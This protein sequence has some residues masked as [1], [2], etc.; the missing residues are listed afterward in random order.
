VF[1]LIDLILSPV[2]CITAPLAAD[3]ETIETT[4]RLTRLTYGWSLAG[5]PALAVPCGFAGG[6]PVGLQLAAAPLREA[7]LLRAGSAYQR[8]TDW[9]LRRP[10]LAEWKEGEDEAR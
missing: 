3:C 8:E 7:T 4:R 5:M 2:S 9:H 1:E 10:A 6:L